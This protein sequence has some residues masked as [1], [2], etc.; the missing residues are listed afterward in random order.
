MTE[1]RTYEE[2]WDHRED[3]KATCAMCGDIIDK[4]KLKASLLKNKG[5]NL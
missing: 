4:K 1:Y 2:D 3:P 5:N